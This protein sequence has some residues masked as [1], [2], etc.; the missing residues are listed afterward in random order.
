MKKN[1]LPGIPEDNQ[2]RS[3]KILEDSASF[4]NTSHSYY[5]HNTSQLYREAEYQSIPN[6]KINHSEKTNQILNK[7]KPMYGG[8]VNEQMIASK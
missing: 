4:M 2:E 1:P 7:I 6:K 5:N 8:T 3:S